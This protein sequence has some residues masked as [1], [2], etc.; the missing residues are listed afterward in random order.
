MAKVYARTLLV[1]AFFIWPYE[2]NHS[3]TIADKKPAAW[4]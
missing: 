2:Q 3:K 1:Q 4:R